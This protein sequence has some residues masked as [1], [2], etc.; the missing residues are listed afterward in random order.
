MGSHDAEEISL[1]AIDQLPA[2]SRGD[3]PPMLLSGTTC[4]LELLNIKEDRIPLTTLSTS[5]LG[6]TNQD[7]NGKTSS[8]ISPLPLL[9][10]QWMCIH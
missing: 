9:Q 3:P 6:T 1:I 7:S 8:M 10:S 4:E 2:S 5:V